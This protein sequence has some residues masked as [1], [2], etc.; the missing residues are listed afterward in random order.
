MAVGGPDEVTERCNALLDAGLDGLTF[1]M[2]AADGHDPDAV[3]FA[4]EV[5]GKVLAS[6]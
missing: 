4:G 6:R 5:L 2:L 1:N 3:A